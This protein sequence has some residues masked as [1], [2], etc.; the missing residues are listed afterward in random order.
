MT[1]TY[2]LARRLARLRNGS[3]FLLPLLAACAAGA[4]T[5]PSNDPPPDTGSDG[6]VALSPRTVTLEG[7]Q[8][9]L[10]RAFE[11]LIPG[12]SQVTSIEWTATGG[13]IAGDGNYTS[14]ATGAFKVIGR[15]KGNPHNLPDTST[16]IVVPVQTTLTAVQVTPSTATVGGGLQQQFSAVGVQSDGSQVPIGVTWTASGGTIDAG[17]LYTAGFAAGTYRVIATHVTTGLADTAVVTVPPATLTSITLSPSSASLSAGQSQ[18]FVVA[19]KLSDGTT[20]SSVPVAYTATGGSVSVTGYYTAGSTG[21]TFR[22]IATAQGGQAD[23]STVTITATTTTSL[24]YNASFETGA[25]PSGTSLEQCVP[26]RIQIYSA[27]NKPTGAP[28]PRSGSW[29]AG[30][31]VY[32]TDVS[33]CTPTVNPR[34]QSSSGSLFAPGREV[35]EQF[36]V[37][38]PTSFPTPTSW[39][40]FQQDYGSPFNSVPPSAWYIAVYSGV[41]HLQ[42]TGLYNA[43]VVQPIWHAPLT[44]GV[45]HTFLV[46]KRFATDKTGFVEAWVDGSRVIPLTYMQT[47]LGGATSASFYLNHYRDLDA[48]TSS[49]TIYFDEAKVGTTQSAVAASPTLLATGP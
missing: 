8:Q 2:K 18:Q 10:F 45:W 48:I 23:T 22:V 47:M 11:S 20:T 6:P 28:D 41:P 1:Y 35:W 30:F 40:L 31:T 39:F 15:R 19:G 43:G 34:A 33:P 25:W 3:A 21:G 36:S 27:A 7:T 12:S 4:P 46:H 13:S 29:A 5:G 38:F 26:G 44:R 37:F 16:V 42:L 24:L 49:A 17:G 32:N 14:A 9:V